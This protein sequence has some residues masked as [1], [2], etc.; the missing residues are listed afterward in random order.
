MSG[1]QTA[2]AHSNI[3]LV[4]Y[5]GKNQESL[6]TPA[7]GSI[8]LTLD[9]LFT[10]TSV[11]FGDALSSDMVLFD[12]SPAPAK[13]HER[14]SA[15][16]NLIR[17]KA[18][19]KHSARV[20]TVNNFP[21]AAGL[22]SSASGFAALTLA[23]VSSAG[24]DLSPIELS[25][26]ARRGSGSAAR[27]V[28]GGLTEMNAGQNPDGSDSYAVQLYPESYW[29]LHMVITI[30][31]DQEKP[32]G[33]T[34][35]MN[36]T[37]QTSPYYNTWIASSHQDLDDMRDALKRQNFQKVGEITEQSCLKMHAVGMSAHPGIIYW[38]PETVQIMH[39]VRELRKDG[40][41]AYFTIDAGPQV[42]VLCRAADATKIAA[43]LNEEP[44]VSRVISCSAGPGA[45]LIE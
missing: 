25:L 34:E 1:K 23:A 27:S 22:A 4:K 40:I 31:S 10:T 35:G 21:T 5:W 14:I 39:L 24:L 33:S 41:E 20:E 29:D 8:S 18:D 6:N 44:A 37:R 17:M 12:G 36:R 15:F 16:L 26:L 32:V 30:L 42:K 19:I 3:A 38:H 9:N 43:I 45:H 11:E 7:V 28:Y 2:R 13:V